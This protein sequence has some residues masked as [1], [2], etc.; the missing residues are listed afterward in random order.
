K[1]RHGATSVFDGV[2][3]RS[4]QC[5]ALVAGNVQMTL[6]DGDFNMPLTGRHVQA[7][8]KQ[9]AG[10]LVYQASGNTSSDGR[11]HFTLEG[12][13]AGGV[14]VL[15]AINPLGIGKHYFSP[16]IMTSGPQDF[17]VTRDGENTLDLEAPVVFIGQPLD[18]ANVS[19]NGFTVRGEAS[20][21]RAIDTLAVTVDSG[22][23]TTTLAA[24][25]NGATGSWQATIPGDLLSDGV[26]A[27]IQ[28][29]A[30][31]QARNAGSDA[32]T[33]VPIIDNEGPQ[34]T[35]TSHQDD[36]LVPVT[37]FLLSGNVTDLTGIDSLTAT[38]EDPELGVTVNGE[39]VDFSNA[40]GAFTLAVQNGEVSE[41]ATVTIAMT[42]VDSD[43]N[44][45]TQTIRLIAAPVSHAGW[46]VLNRVTFGPT[47][48]LLEE[49]ATIGIDSFIEQQL[50]PSSIDDSAFESSLGPDPT[51][52]AELQ[53][54][55]LRHMILS[56]RQLREVLTWFWDNHFNTDLNTTRTNAD[57]DA[58][59]DTVAYELAE[60]Q[61][62]RANALGNFGDLLSASAKSPAMLIY[63]DGISNVAENSNENHA[64][65][66]L[67]LHAMGVDGGYTEADVAAA[68][69]VLTGWHLDT[70][71]GEFFFDAT[72]HNFADQ[73]VLGET[74]GG[75][76]EQ[77]EAMLDHLARHP[78][79]AQYVC[80]KLVEVFV[81]DAPP[82]AM[83]SRC[84]QTFLDNSDS[85]E[86]IAEVMR[87][88]LSNEFFDID[89]FRAKI[90]TPVEF[91]VG[92]VRNLLATSDGTDLAD[93][94]ADMGLRLYQNPVP[95][96]YSEIGGDWINSSLLI[97]R[98]KWVNELAR[99]P[100]DG[101]GTGID[102]ANFFSSY[103]FETAEG[104]VGFLLNLTVGDD[105]TDLARQQALD[106][107]NGVN[108]FDLT[109]VDARERLRQLI[110]VV[111]SYPGYQ[112]Q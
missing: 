41:N 93:P 71:T 62:F 63:L 99:E 43:G 100:V 46:Q 70:S 9:P 49:L 109:D 16:F 80:G 3:C 21:N 13:D 112:F 107:L 29:T 47:P 22:G 38:V 103:G 74:F 87:T 110:G 53:A 2:D 23:A 101:A 45:S 50:D 7:Y 67:E 94:V 57:G 26:A 105:F 91:V 82:E 81:N 66:L 52:L 54:W 20:D 31:D 33:V 64:R 44:A 76:L 97:E 1:V 98:I 5:D 56:R 102:P 86:Q 61:A 24:Q 4:G 95:T 75:G 59:S 32:I 35:F 60:N 85:P 77:G 96:G 12:I 42:A 6:I 55:T 58:V 10:K 17:V 78:A 25:F 108:G 15:K 36:D 18:L 88:I 84:A 19:I 27:S 8:S 73:V 83:I 30:T 79:T 14:F 28:V 69:E 106:L 11:I 65:E 39:D 37:G 68:A 51:T 89:N 48:A 90:K 104:I 72:R 111:L 34:I 92:A 40:S